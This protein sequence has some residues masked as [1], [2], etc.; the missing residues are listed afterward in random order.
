MT[1]KVRK[2]YLNYKSNINT[3]EI[4]NTSHMVS[5]L[6]GVIVQPNK[7]IV[8]G[9]AFAHESGIH[10]DG[11]LKNRNT[12]EIMT[13]DEVGV[14]KTK[15][16][17]GRHSGRHGLKARLTEL[18]Y[19]VSQDDLIKL[20]ELFTELADRK[21]EVYDDDLRVLMGDEIYKKESYVQLE[22]MQVHLGTR[23]IPTATVSLKISNNIIQESATGDGPVD[24]V[25][26]SIDRALD[27]E[28][29]I[30]SYQVRSVTEGRQAMGEALIRIRIGAKTF[31][32]RGVSTDI[33]EAS[34][35]AYLHAINLLEIEKNTKYE[36]KVVEL[37]EER[38]L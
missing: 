2:D 21:K 20:Y 6:T 1:L 16:V 5:G 8:G 29:K 37:E 27:T 9:N 15:I 36:K 19:T 30:E 4:Y 35:K 22:Q 7:A 13:P 31:T 28:Y 25:F 12:Y 10:Q 38:Q 24:A 18:G 23:T 34:A 26:N 32:G 33:I 3:R 17:L 11:M 14:P